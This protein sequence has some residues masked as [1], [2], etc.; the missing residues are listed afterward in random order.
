M[1]RY[2]RNIFTVGIA[3]IF[4]I[5]AVF[6]TLSAVFTD[7]VLILTGSGGFSRGFGTTPTWFYRTEDPISFWAAIVVPWAFAIYTNYRLWR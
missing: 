2:D 6:N 4:A 1:K 3:A 5:A 7:S